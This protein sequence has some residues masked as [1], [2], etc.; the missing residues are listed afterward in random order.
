MSKLQLSTPMDD[1][2]RARPLLGKTV[3]FDEAESVYMTHSLE[4]SFSRAFHNVELDI[5]ESPF[6]SYLIKPS[7]V[8]YPN[9]EIPVFL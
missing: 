7:K 1:Y 5:C 4:E 3:L 2:D 8:E 9:T 6:A